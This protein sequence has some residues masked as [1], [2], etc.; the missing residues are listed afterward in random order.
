MPQKKSKLTKSEE[1]VSSTTVHSA[2]QG[3]EST[4]LVKYFKYLLD[5][6]FTGVFANDFPIHCTQ[7]GL[8]S[9]SVK[10]LDSATLK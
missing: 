3:K 6:Q 10:P 8:P 9:I 5:S 1:S 2:A 7:N 4:R